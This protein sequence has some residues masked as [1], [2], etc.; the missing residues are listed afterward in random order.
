MS[1]PRESAPHGT[2]IDWEEAHRRLDQIVERL[3]GVTTRA[4]FDAQMARRAAE[5]AEPDPTGAQAASR[6]IIA[7]GLAGERYAIEVEAAAAVAP[8]DQLVVLPGLDPVHLGVVVHRGVVHALI[9]PNALLGRPVAG[10]PAPALAVLVAAPDCAIGLAADI[11]FGVRRERE[12][13]LSAASPTS[14]ITAILPD[15]TSLLAA[16]ALARNAR[17]IVDHRMRPSGSI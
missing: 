1:A 13:S 14:I 3:E 5:L 4:A 10:T 9:D 6:D 7:F 2:A 8:L 16:D 17:L 12:D 11:V 15:G